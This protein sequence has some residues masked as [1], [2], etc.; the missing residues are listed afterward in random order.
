M[1]EFLADEDLDV[2]I[3]DDDALEADLC[4]PKAW[5]DSMDRLCM[6]SK[7]DIKK[8]GMPS[9]DIG[10]AAALTFAEQVIDIE[11]SLMSRPDQS[12]YA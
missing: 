4:C 12:I 1:H 11:E 3:P 8:R 5:Y 2:Q 7:D 9:P 6:E 10:D